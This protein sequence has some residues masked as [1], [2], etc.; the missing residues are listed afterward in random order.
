VGIA[1]GLPVGLIVLTEWQHALR[2]RDSFL[3]RPVTLLRNY[4]LPL[5]ALLL[6]LIEAKQVP[7]SATP[8]RMVATLF[9]FVVLVL[10]LSGVNATLFQGAPAGRGRKRVP[11]I[12][13]DVGRF[14]VIRGWPGADL[15]HHLGRE[16]AR[17]I[18]LRSA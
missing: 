15:L 13:I 16:R 7:P 8:V 17:A 5:G 3:V 18:L 10:V 2:R 9:A 6:L 4:L 12:F 11:T 14:L 1:I